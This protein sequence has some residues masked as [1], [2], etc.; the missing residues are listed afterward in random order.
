MFEIRERSEEAAKTLSHGP[1]VFHEALSGGGRRYH[2]SHPG[3]EDYDIVYTKNYDY[4]LPIMPEAY[5]HLEVFWDFFSYDEDDDD[6]IVLDQFEMCKKVV[7]QELNEYTIAIGRVL[8]RKTDIELYYADSRI[9]WF[10]PENEKLHAGG[11]LPEDTPDVLFVTQPL[12]NSYQNTTGN[13][14]SVLAVFQS[15]FYLQAVTEKDTEA[16]KYIHLSFDSHLSGIGAIMSTVARYDSIFKPAGW[17]AYVAGG[18]LGKYPREML[19]K[20]LN[21][22][23]LPADASEE[24]T[25]FVD[26]ILMSRLGVTY[27]GIHANSVPGIEWFKEK[28]LKEM[29]EYAEAVI[30]DKKMLGVYIR[31]TDYITT[32]K[33]G[34]GKHASVSE[35]IPVI[36]EWM[37]ADHFD[38]IFLA[39]EDEDI[40]RKMREEFGS[41][42]RVVAQERFRVDEFKTVRLIGELEDLK[43]KPEEKEEHIEDMTVNYFYAMYMLAKCD[44]F[45]CF[46]ESNGIDL[47]NCFNRGQFRYQVPLQNY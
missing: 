13:K 36:H 3:G 30:E 32:N 16:I 29:D 2:V 11:A 27:N 28:L 38:G 22:P 21:I 8:L 44:S 24:N 42:V 46:G 20:Y 15:M 40:L 9:Y 17:K 31:G 47:V 34:L 23:L 12:G 25:L 4:I 45:I 14:L 5:R 39:T 1:S 41:L 6:H 43:Y 37:A 7:F 18:R 33:P 26:L 10:L 19:D 35:V